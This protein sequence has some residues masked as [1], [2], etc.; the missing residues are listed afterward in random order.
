M[1]HKKRIKKTQEMRIP[2]PVNSLLIQLLIDYLKNKDWPDDTPIFFRTRSWAN[3]ILNKVGE[4]KDIKLWPHLFRHSHAA[5]LAESAQSPKA[6]T[7]I[8][9][10]MQ[11]SS[12]DQTYQY[13]ERFNV[14]EEREML[15]KNWSIK[16]T[17]PTKFQNN[18]ID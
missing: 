11:H 12:A 6:V 3:K 13:I 10:Q 14:K 18:K 2:V 5:R 4:E 1:I 17:K 8:K 7:M 9:S 16:N 15:D